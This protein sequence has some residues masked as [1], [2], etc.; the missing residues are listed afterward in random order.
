MDK[1]YQ[2][3]T[4]FVRPLTVFIYLTSACYFYFS[5]PPMPE[6]GLPRLKMLPIIM[7]AYLKASFRCTTNPPHAIHIL[8]YLLISDYRYYSYCVWIISQDTIISNCKSGN[9]DI[10]QAWNIARCSAI[11]LK[12]CK[13]RYQNYV[14][15]PGCS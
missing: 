6:M 12:K 13:A 5:N 3:N 2:L 4:M 14:Y 9:T 1:M 8:I 10:E 7:T 11:S 15:I